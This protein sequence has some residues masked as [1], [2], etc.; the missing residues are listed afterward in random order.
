MITNIGQSPNIVVFQVFQMNFEELIDD[1][2]SFKDD[3]LHE[4]TV[5]EVNIQ[6]D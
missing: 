1:I 5:Y 6:I 2:K 3:W 4:E